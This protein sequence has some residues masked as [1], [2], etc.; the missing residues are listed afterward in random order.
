MNHPTLLL[1]ASIAGIVLSAWCGTAAAQD[2]YKAR[3][4]M[5]QAAAL[6]KQADAAI[7]D[8]MGTYGKC[9]AEAGKLN[10]EAREKSAHNGLLETEMYYKKRAAYHAYRAERAA[11]KVSPGAA[12]DKATRTTVQLSAHHW[13][14]RSGALRWPTLLQSAAYDFLRRKV[15]GLLENRTLTDS[16]AGSLN[17]VKTMAVVND[18]RS[19]LRGHI[20]HYSSADYMVARK[21][22]DAVATEAQRPVGGPERETLDRVAKN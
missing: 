8:S 18:L 16:G 7:I 1:R 22:L 11:K 15:D 2:I 10:E 3:T 17:C 13:D 5:L 6:N 12:P 4:E 21:F 19:E 14:H 9:Q 20:T